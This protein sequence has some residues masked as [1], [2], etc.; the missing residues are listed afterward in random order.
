MG[1]SLPFSSPPFPFM[2]FRPFLFACLCFI[3]LPLSAQ[4][5]NS[6]PIT[7]AFSSM[8]LSHVPST[9][10]M[11]E[12]AFQSR[13]DAVESGYQVTLTPHPG[14]YIYHDKIKVEGVELNI[15]SGVI[16]EDPLFGT[17]EVHPYPVSF[18]VPSSTVTL[19]FQGCQD[20]G[21]CYP[22]MKR[23][24]SI[25]SLSATPLQDTIEK[26]APSSSAATLHEEGYAFLWAFFG[27][28]LLLAL[29]PCTWP[30]LP[31][32]SNIILGQDAAQSNWRRSLG[33]GSTYVFSHALVF[34]GMGAISA[35]IGFTL[36]LWIQQWYVI[37]PIAIA[38][39]GLGILMIMGKAIQIPASV[40]H[41]ASQKG[42]GGKW[43]GVALLGAFSALMLGPCIAPPLAGA[44]LF[45]TQTHDVAKGA[46]ALFVLGLGMGIPLMAIVLGVSNVLPKMGRIVP[47]LGKYIP[48]VLGGGMIALGTYLLMPFW[49]SWWLI[50]FAIAGGLWVHYS[51]Q[52]KKEWIGKSLISTLAVSV[53]AIGAYY[54]D[55][56]SDPSHMDFQSVASHSE[57][58]KALKTAKPEQWVMVDFYA[59]WCTEC[60]RMEKNTFSNSTTQAMMKDSNIIKVKVDLT[61]MN[62]EK[63][64]LLKEYGVVGPP[65]ILFF[66]HGKEQSNQRLVG[67]ES[68]SKF[69]QRLQ[70]V[71]NCPTHTEKQ[72]MT[73]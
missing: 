30:M 47:N 16:E 64:A 26:T 21:I 41:W 68:S 73:C 20:S 18:N 49:A 29:S 56:S 11:A 67:F 24:L 71:Y 40:Q 65:M 10:L 60:L 46:L 61:E 39:M 6:S 53:L 48:F 44:M 4:T 52:E 32:L 51:W 45:I 42:T 3:T 14:Y 31:I 57:L 66:K 1:V 23:H 22:P 7:H 19:Q 63:E 72:S 38:V 58:N 54:Q 15:P 62:Q 35:S 2:K 36:S 55:T 13:I 25:A 34:A 28:G 5:S 37:V 27:L 43:S 70:A 8:T 9:P 12:L 33:L 17:V 50:L 69:N 59:D